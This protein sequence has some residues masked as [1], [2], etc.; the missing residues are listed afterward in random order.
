MMVGAPV[1]NESP[2]DLMD[3]YLRE[4]SA[5]PLLSPEQ[6]VSLA[7]K[8]LDGDLEARRTLVK[9]NLRLVISIAK[10]Y[11]H[12]GLPLLDLIEEGNLGL[13]KAVE[14]Y[15]PNRGTRFSTYASW[16]IK[17]S[18]IRAIASQGRTVRIP[19]HMFDLINKWFRVSHELTQRLGRA[20]SVAETA[21]EMS[22][23][24]EKVK[25]I[26]RSAQRTASLHEPI[27]D[28][29][30]DLIGDL[31]HDQQVVNPLDDLEQKFAHEEIQLY[32]DR[33]PQRE[34]DVLRL[35]YGLDDENLRARYQLTREPPLT[36]EETGQI[37]GVTRERIRQIE[38]QALSKLKVMIEEAE[39]QFAESFLKEV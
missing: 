22:L 10:R 7:I 36:L 30:G 21:R 14:R 1:H 12:R 23:S 26:V 19:A 25:E 32:L 6:E 15:D 2:C 16:W 38:S 20:P 39:R 18:V 5:I 3:L 4:V 11:I 13:M 28:E 34:A 17:Q 24:E 27:R 31:L 33:L 8:V 35:R 9:S 37:F 29:G